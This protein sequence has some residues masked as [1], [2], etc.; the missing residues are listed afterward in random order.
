M[1]IFT[2]IQLLCLA[3]LWVV[4]STAAALAFPFFLIMLVPVR[5]ILGRVF[6]PSE[7]EAVSRYLL[8]FFFVPPKTSFG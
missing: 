8:S 1:H 5:K 2:G 6:L 7:L 4:K 3:V